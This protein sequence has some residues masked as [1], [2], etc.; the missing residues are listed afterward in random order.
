MP[1]IGTSRHVLAE[2]HVLAEGHVL[3][4][5]HL[6]AEG[7]LGHMPAYGAAHVS[8]LVLLV[9][10]AVVLVRWARRG[11]PERVDR[12]LRIA[13]WVLLANAVFWT[14]WGFMPWAWNLEESLPLHYSDALRFLLPIALIIRAPWAIVVSWFWGL[15]LNMQS[16][17]TP[18]VNYFV[19]IPLEFVEYWIAHLS[20]VL[21]PVVLVWGLRFHPTWRGCGL[22]YAATVLWAAIAFTGN[23]LTGANYGYLNRAPDGASILDLLGPWP[24]YLLVEA[25]LIAVVWALMT[26]PW[27]LLDRRGGTP[28]PGRAGLVRRPRDAQAS[29]STSASRSGPWEVVITRR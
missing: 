14:A 11:E 26:L 5:G 3:A 12:V 10:A 17:L 2:E 7:A 29:S 21:G 13:G 1:E 27:V 28:A 15:T 4:K 24:Q 23:A 9:M 16:V 19:W 6:V 25:V 22:A 18:D 20:G 8:M